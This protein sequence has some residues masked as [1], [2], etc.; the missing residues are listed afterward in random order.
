MFGLSGVPQGSVLGPILF[1]IY[2]NVVLFVVCHQIT[3]Y[4]PKVSFRGRDSRRDQTAVLI[5]HYNKGRSL[6]VVTN[7]EYVFLLKWRLE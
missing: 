2:I 5:C 7:S 6:L 4:F 1:L 3:T